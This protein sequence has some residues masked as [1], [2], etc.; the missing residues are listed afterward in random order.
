MDVFETILN[1]LHETKSVFPIKYQASVS[2][3]TNQWKVEETFVEDTFHK[4]SR[5]T[6]AGNKKNA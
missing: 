1:S 5:F 6:I 2:W 4:N 3:S